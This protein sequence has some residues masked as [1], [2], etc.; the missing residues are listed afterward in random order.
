M[1]RR[2]WRVRSDPS[3]Y[4]DGKI[5]GYGGP[6]DAHLHSFKL[7]PDGFEKPAYR[8]VLTAIGEALE[9]ADAD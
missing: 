4:A 8:A 7:L 9:Q 1:S 3:R 2:H 6:S 5:Q